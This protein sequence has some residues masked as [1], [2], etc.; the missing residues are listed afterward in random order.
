MSPA[1]PY[2]TVEVRETT[3]VLINEDGL[4]AE[5]PLDGHDTIPHLHQIL[6]RHPG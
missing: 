4:L 3:R 5:V 2:E 6:D 1:F